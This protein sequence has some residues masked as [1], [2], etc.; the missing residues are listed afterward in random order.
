MLSASV[1]FVLN[2]VFR[3]LIIVPEKDFYVAIIDGHLLHPLQVNPFL[4]EDVGHRLLT[5]LTKSRYVRQGL[6]SRNSMVGMFPGPMNE[7]SLNL[8]EFLED[9]FGK[10]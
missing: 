3:R 7:G 10:G 2:A 9:G 6:L 4:T 5:S 1:S 8:S